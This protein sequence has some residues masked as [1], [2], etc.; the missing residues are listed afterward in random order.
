MSLGKTV[1]IRIDATSHIGSGHAMRC[2]AIAQAVEEIGGE[3]RFA[4][5]CDESA[6]FLLSRGYAAEVLGGDPMRL[7]GADAD[8]LGVYC[9]AL[10]ADALFIDTYGVTKAFFDSL[11][12]LRDAGVRVGY[13][14][15]LYTFEL[16]ITAVPVRREVD[17]VLNYSLYADEEAYAGSYASCGADLLL[18]PAYAPLRREFWEPA[19]RGCR[20]DVRDVLV[21]AGA[22]NPGRS[23]ERFASLAR[24]AFPSAD[25]HVVVGPSAVFEGSADGLDIL[26][27][28]GSLLP[29]MLGCDVC[30]TAA[31]TTLYELSALGAP[32]LA[33]AI[34]DN[35]LE[36]AMA[37]R[38][39]GLG[40]AHRVTDSDDDLLVDLRALRKP[41]VR[42][43]LSGKM[44]ETVRGDGAI[45][46]A[47]R[48]LPLNRVLV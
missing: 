43:G 8:A 13:L 46:I 28:Q 20:D 34:V 11:R 36:N 5:S 44:R 31:G 47:R 23:L 48:L 45:G 10:G 32:S 21:T 3:V 6:S 41:D 14:D 15:D 39:L 2:I 16:G 22:T 25:I 17:L 30:I 12:G 7:G 40:F 19:D 35:Q 9:Q 18:G 38:R 37:F 24:E 26:G 29:L 4:V 27:P 42:L 33:V 1:V